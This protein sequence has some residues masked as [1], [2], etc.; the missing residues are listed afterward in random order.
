MLRGFHT[1]ESVGG[2]GRSIRAEILER[3]HDAWARLL[4][5]F[6][7]VYGGIEHP[8]MRL[9]AL[10]GSLF[11]P[12]KYPFLEGR[13][14]GTSWKECNPTPLPIDNRTVLLLLTSLQVL[15]QPG[16]AILLSYRALDVEQ[17]GH[18]YE[19]L[20]EHTAIRAADITLGL[21]GSAKAKN[22]NVGLAE[23]ESLALDSEK[24]L[25]DRVKEI[26]GRSPAA[27]KNAY[28]RTPD[29]ALLAK[30]SAVCGGKMEL[31]E[32]I[33]P[34]AN[35]LRLDAWE[36]PLVYHKDAFMVTMGQDRRDSGTHY[37]PKIL[38]EKIV[39][40]TLD[41]V[42]YHGPA[43]G[44]PREEWILKSPAE[45]LNLK[46][47]DPAMGSGAFLVQV[48]RYLSE[49]LF[50]AWHKAEEQGKFIDS[51]GNV[52]DQPIAEPMT[53]LVDDRMNAA[54]RL[55]GRKVSLRSRYQPVGSGIG[56]TLHLAG[57]HFQGTPLRILGSQFEIRRQSARHSRY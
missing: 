57:H 50:E 8:E 10:G 33:T 35:W 37:T 6:R 31:A 47:C 25:F 48:C 45:L 40:T 24:K 14:K 42:V 16:G 55:I 30:I 54:R 49:R 32:R 46:I 34:Y 7:A 19:G 13:A 51:E 27:I 20:L 21:S 53:K 22:P 23:L 41:P 9:P 56:K 39:K 5:V 11:N 29:P 28:R 17:I 26:T 44:T 52:S 36:Q 38:T 4:A 2:G 1:A 3:R 18:I 12:D 15:E 43:E